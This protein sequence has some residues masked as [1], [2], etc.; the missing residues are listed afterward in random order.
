MNRRLASKVQ[1]GRFLK[2]ILP[3]AAILIAGILGL[4]GFLV[5]RIS[6]P[7]AVP[8]HV[9]PS[10]FLL[11]SLELSIPSGDGAEIQSWWIPGLKGA[12]GIVLARIRDEPVGCIEPCRGY[13]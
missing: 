1:I 12:P 2:T 5:Y 3:A 13:A 4:F 6:N 11:P 9:N 10:H 7:G 8:E